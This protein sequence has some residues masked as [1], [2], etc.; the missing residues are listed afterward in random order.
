MVFRVLI[1]FLLVCWLHFSAVLMQ[2]WFNW[3]IVELTTLTL[4]PLLYL[5]STCMPARLAPAM[6]S[7]WHEYTLHLLNFLVTGLCNSLLN[8]WFLKIP[9][10]VCPAFWAILNTL[11][12]TLSEAVLLGKI[13]K[14]SI[15]KSPY[16]IS[17]WKQ[18]LPSS[19]FFFSYNND[20]HILQTNN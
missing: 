4:A 15:S 5:L 12:N 2:P 9:V 7:W 20:D 6:L 10:F 8:S 14:L 18:A 19:F 3:S 1:F 17:C 13:Y 16:A 11:C